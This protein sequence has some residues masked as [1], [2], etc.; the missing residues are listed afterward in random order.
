M[1]KVAKRTRKTL[2][3]LRMKGQKVLNFQRMLMK[4]QMLM[5][6]MM[7]GKTLIMRRK[8]GK[9]D[10]EKRSRRRRKKVKKTIC[11]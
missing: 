11:S 1:I 10:Q 5:M 9:K 3:L 7:Q 2:S 6:K 8:E 4:G